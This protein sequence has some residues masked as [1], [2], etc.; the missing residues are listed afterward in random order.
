M[1]RVGRVARGTAKVTGVSFKKALAVLVPP[2][3]L[4]ESSFFGG[5]NRMS[6][7]IVNLGD[8]SRSATSKGKQYLI[9]KSGG[10]IADGAIGLALFG[11]PMTL[12]TSLFSD[13][14][15]VASKVLRD[16]GRGDENTAAASGFFGDMSAVSNNF[17]KLFDVPSR[18]VANDV[19]VSIDAMAAR[20]K[21]EGRLTKKIQDDLSRLDHMVVCPL[22]DKSKWCYM[23]QDQLARIAEDSLAS[24]KI[25]HGAPEIRKFVSRPTVKNIK[26]MKDS[27]V[28]DLNKR[29]IPVSENNKEF[30]DALVDSLEGFSTNEFQTR[31]RT[32]TATSAEIAGEAEGAAEKAAASGYRIIASLANTTYKGASLFSR[33]YKRQIAWRRRQ[34]EVRLE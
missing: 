16:A 14:C 26:G 21:E 23:V 17:A 19:H 7:A 24:Q 34:E 9:R 28:R 27:I 30:A 18:E 33:H 20:L 12:V 1:K 22:G 31:L 2:Q 11:M 8:E 6:D 10:T 25:R 15:K 29:R 5:L 3:I 32:L 4:K 13:G